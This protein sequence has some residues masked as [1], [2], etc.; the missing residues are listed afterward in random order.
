MDQAGVATAIN[1]MTSP[2]VWFEDGE[3]ARGRT[4]VLQ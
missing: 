4:R 1:S 2:G 3:A